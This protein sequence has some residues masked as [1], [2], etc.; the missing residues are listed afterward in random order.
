MSKSDQV[1]RFTRVISSPNSGFENSHITLMR[2]EPAIRSDPYSEARIA[3][4]LWSVFF[5]VFFIFSP[6]LPPPSSSLLFFISP[7]SLRPVSGEWSR[8]WLLLVIWWLVFRKNTNYIT[9]MTDWVKR[10]KN[11]SVNQSFLLLKQHQNDK[12]TY[13]FMCSRVKATLTSETITK[14]SGPVYKGT[15]AKDSTEK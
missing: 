7:S 2:F 14:H 3:T 10:I 1:W 6:P 5:F 11:Q 9:F 13:R 8:I 4:P 15:K 12:L